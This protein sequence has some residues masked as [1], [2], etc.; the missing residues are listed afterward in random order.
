MAAGLYPAGTEFLNTLRY[1]AVSDS[2]N[3][4]MAPR[5]KEIRYARKLKWL[6]Y[7]ELET[8]ALDEVKE[9]D[10]FP[11]RL[12]LPMGNLEEGVSNGV[13]WVYQG[14]IEDAA[15]DLRPQT[16]EETASCIGCHGGIGATTDSSFAL[17]RKFDSTTFQEG[18][19]HWTQKDLKDVNEP[20]ATF[21]D[22][23]RRLIPE[24]A[25]VLHEDISILLFPS[26]ERAMTL[27]KVYKTIVEKQS[28]TLGWT[29][30]VADKTEVYESLTPVD[31]E[32]GV[33]KIMNLTDH[34]RNKSCAPCTLPASDPIQAEQQTAVNGNGMGGPNGESYLIDTV[35]AVIFLYSADLP[36][37]SVAIAN[38]DDAGDIA[39]A[40]A[41]SMLVV[42]TNIIVRLTFSMVTAKLKGRST[43]WT[44]K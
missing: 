7:A 41:M 24:M 42:A 40:C 25:K 14:F 33:L 37:A 35:S 34:T 8:L 32:T 22:E 3:I 23:N 15:G 38:M 43:A 17:A 20:K 11:D 36:L 16:F 18:W 1:V 21:L 2:G 13:G 4:E 5:M 19:H 26:P 29:P 10:D 39:P 30:L 27:K 9:R 12:K 44:K 28:F 6:T 31:L